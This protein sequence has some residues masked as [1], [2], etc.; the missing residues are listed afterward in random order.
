LGVELFR[1][2]AEDDEVVG[3]WAEDA[4]VT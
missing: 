4:H 3:R 1:G 2:D